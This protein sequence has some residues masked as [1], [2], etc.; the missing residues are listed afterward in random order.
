M[1]NSEIHALVQATDHSRAE[2]NRRNMSADTFRFSTAALNANQNATRS[3]VCSNEM[4]PSPKPFVRTRSSNGRNASHVNTCNQ[5]DQ[6]G[7][8]TES[9]P[10]DG[11]LEALANLNMYVDAPST[12][13]FHD[14]NFSL[15]S[16]VPLVE[17]VNKD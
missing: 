7:K 5:K 9:D 2:S 10:F 3:T 13:E 16:F 14:K 17:P 1:V 8:S 11:I 4:K 6:A 12:E 15:N